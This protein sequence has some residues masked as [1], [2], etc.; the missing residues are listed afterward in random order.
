MEL[1]KTDKVSFVIGV[2]PGYFHNNNN[3][4]SL[5]KLARDVDK[6]AKKA[7][8]IQG[9]YVAFNISY[10][11]TMYKTEWGCPDGGERTFTISAV[12]N[13]KFNKD[14]D[15]WK[16]ACITAISALREE[17]KQSTVTIEFSE[18]EMIYLEGGDDE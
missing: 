11:V 17:L 14:S 6:A 5:S 10:G 7:E 13:P 12:R 15:Q 16:W 18:I 4:V 2:N 3:K 8:E 9:C 1:L